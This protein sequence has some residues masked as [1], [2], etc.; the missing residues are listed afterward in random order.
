[1]AMFSAT[2]APRAEMPARESART[3][4]GAMRYAKACHAVKAARSAAIR[5]HSAA[6]MRAEALLLFT[7]L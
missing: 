2:Y 5:M 1:M 4:A 3:V 7:M 6:R